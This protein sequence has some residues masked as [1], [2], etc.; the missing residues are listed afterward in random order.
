MT[1]LSTLRERVESYSDLTDQKLMR[2]LPIIVVLNGRSFKKTTSLLTKPFCPV[3]AEA[4]CA[5]MIKL[6]Q[7]IDGTTFA[8]SF[9]DEI[10]L[11]VRNDQTPET[12]AW[13]DNRIQKIVSVSASIATFEFNRIAK[14]NEMQTLGDPIFSA[15]TFT[16]PN[17][18]EAINVLVA[19]QQQAFHTAL[20]MAC[21]Y[22]L[23]KNHSPETVQQTLS[24]KSPQAKAEILF[25]ECNIDF[26]NYP[27]PFRRGFA[28]YRVPRVI[29]TAEGEEIKNKLTIDMEIPLFTKNHD[30][31]GQIFK[32]GRDIFR[33]RE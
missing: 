19:K 7:E 4:M 2:K 5:V 12:G 29:N 6:S 27:L 25:E 33:V 26:N 24:E 3:F 31:L 32:S 11:V 15:Q 1:A 22:E 23:L 28:C 20:S 18:T 9:N 14:I 17:I 8:Y 21:F 16:V 10:V 30:F 13:Y